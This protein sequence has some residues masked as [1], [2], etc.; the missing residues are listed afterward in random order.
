MRAY[1]DT[2]DGRVHAVG[3]NDRS[4]LCS[5]P[6]LSSSSRDERVDSCSLRAGV[7]QAA[8]PFLGSAYI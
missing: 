5:T 6:S 3:A 8:V 2:L 7:F 4:V 1:G